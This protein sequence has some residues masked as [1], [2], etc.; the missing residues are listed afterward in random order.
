MI[1]VYN[2]KAQPERGLHEG[3]GESF[4]I[5][6][7]EIKL[8]FDTGWKGKHLVN[9]MKILGISPSD[10]QKIIF[11]HGHMDH[12]HGLKELLKSR[13]SDKILEIFGHPAILESKS[14]KMKVLKFFEFRYPSRWVSFP[15]I[16]PKFENTIKYI[17]RREPANITSNIFF[18][19]EI[20]NRSEKD[21]TNEFM[22]HKSKHKWVRDPMLDDQSLIIDS[23]KGLVLICG[24]CHAGLLN[25]CAHVFKIH[26]KK[27]H[28]IIG[29]THMMHF[30]PKEVN[31]VANIL[32][33]TYDTPLL[34][35]NHCKGTKTREIL[36]DRFG[37][38][39]VNPCPVGTELRFDC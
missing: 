23:K 27:I 22:L 10:I 35:L 9:N 13:E 25:T 33:K 24:C 34:F 3:H 36:R 29:G 30:S 2:N 1:N 14:A 26:N 6:S 16:P 37:S 17:L 12:T 4:Y 32:E 39:I 21:G 28:A 31:N 20:T 38:E 15:K 18:S 11:S 7:D 8:L 19:G 5:Q